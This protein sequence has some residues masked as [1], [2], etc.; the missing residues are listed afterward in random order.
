MDPLEKKAL[1]SS[2]LE[3]TR[4]GLG[5]TALTGLEGDTADEEAAQVVHQALSLNLNLFNLFFWRLK[6][7][8]S[9]F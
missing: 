2:G 8:C 3:V 7:H 1:G 9:P 4:L 5:C 6:F